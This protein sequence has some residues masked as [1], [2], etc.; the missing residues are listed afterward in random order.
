M[1]WE[2]SGLQ[3]VVVGFLGRSREVGIVML[4]CERGE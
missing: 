4:T 1:C 2:G 3:Y